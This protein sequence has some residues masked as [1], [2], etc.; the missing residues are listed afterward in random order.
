MMKGAFRLSLAALLLLAL[1]GPGFAQHSGHVRGRVV[2]RVTKQPLA[3]ARVEVMGAERAV[4][5]GSDGSYRI[6]RLDEGVYGLRIGLFGYAEFIHSDVR[7]VRGKTTLVN[8]IELGTAPLHLE[9]VTVTAV[10]APAVSRHSLQREE[11]R[12]SPGSAGDVLRAISSLP[13]VSTTEGEFSAMSVR[14]GGPHDNLILIDNI[15]FDRINHFEGGTRDDE[16]Q[17]G[18]FSI[19][20]AGLV[21][22]ATFH[23]GGFGAEHGRKGAAVLDLTLRE[24]NPASPTVSGSYDVLGLE[25]GYSGPTYLS[26]NTAVLL[27]YRSFDLRRV[28]RLAGNEDFGDPTMSDLIVKTTTRLNPAHEV[29]VVGLYATDRLLRG[30]QHLLKGKDLLQNGLFEVDE[31]RWAVGVNWRWLTSARS[32]LHNTLYLA[33][34]ERLRSY[35]HA[36]ADASGGSLPGSDADLRYRERVGFQD[37]RETEVGWR[38]DFQHTVGMAAMLRVGGE[39]YGIQLD[40]AMIQTGADTIY[41]FTAADRLADPDLKY[42]VVQA[43]DVNHR[44]EGGA[45]HAAAYAALELGVGRLVLTPGL[46]YAHNGFNGRGSLAPRLQAR[47]H[48]TPST[49]LDAATGIYYQAP[50]SRIVAGA[51]ENRSLRDERSTH[52]I[53]GV[54]QLLGD[55]YRLTLEGYYKTYDHLI[56]PATSAHRTSINRGTG[57]NGGFDAILLRRFTDR[58]HAQVSYSFSRGRRND[59]DGLAEYVAPFEEPHAFSTIVGYQLN[60]QWF[61]SGRWK[62][63]TGRPRDR[64]V[65]HE[66]VLGD[67]AMM[68]YSMEI[69]E[70]NAERLPDFHLLTVRGDYRRQLGPLGLV[71]FIELDNLYN[72]MNTYG[73]RFSELTGAE[74]G[75]G[76]GFMGNLGLKLEL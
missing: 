13:G 33:G 49:T 61:V 58:H 75:L 67:P 3:G 22:R 7:V 9:T 25:V 76:L 17:G 10:R 27:N 29:G 31:T 63:A 39:L 20:T 36:T 51:P 56:T 23:G 30:P 54:N 72:R 50:A 57:W 34:N 4:L 73:H 60:R 55:N 48:V 5:S 40:H 24:G 8:E 26:G 18:R 19:L 28:V 70:R 74:K 66:N 47:Y 62:Y 71:M 46:R 11:I 35:G 42:H 65:V 6:E 41:R 68:R 64:F 16:T 43:G 2:D 32:V 45:L 69:T 38:S 1:T 44:F 14:G 53:L 59:H 52:Y 12:R 15:P 37:Q 21:E